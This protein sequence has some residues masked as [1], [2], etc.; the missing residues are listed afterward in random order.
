MVSQLASCPKAGWGGWRTG[1]GLEVRLEFVRAS[2]PS[3]SRDSTDETSAS[4]P[5]GSVER[6]EEV[7]SS[8]VLASSDS[9]SG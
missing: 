8:L 7:E 3:A 2:M 4:G 6:E 5:S 1:Q 9:A